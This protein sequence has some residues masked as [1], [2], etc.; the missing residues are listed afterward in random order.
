MA[1]TTGGGGYNYGAS[2]TVTAVPAVGYLFAN[3]SEDGSAVSTNPSYSFTVSRSRSLLANFTQIPRVLN[4]TGPGGIALRNNDIITISNSDAGSL[5]INVDANAEWT[6][7]ESSLWLKAVKESNTSLRVA[8]MENIS[9]LDKQAS[10]Q[11]HNSI[12]C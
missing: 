1:S 8:Y 5:L 6:A 2:V 11:S 10:S 7:T 3:W 4:L 9:V 12:K